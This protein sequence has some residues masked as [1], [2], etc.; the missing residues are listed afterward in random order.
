MSAEQLE[1][2]RQL[3][4]TLTKM[5][6]T[7]NAIADAVVWVG[8]DRRIQWCNSRFAG[9][10][11]RP[12]SEISGCILSDLL[13]LAQAGK[14]VDVSIYPDV[15]INSGE[16]E[17]TDYEFTQGEVSLLLQISGSCV[18]LNDQHCAVLIIR[19]VTQAQSDISALQLREKALQRSEAQYRD[20]VQTANCII[21]RWDYNGNIIFLNDYGQRFFGFDLDEILGRNVIGT[22]VPE[23]ETSGR[24]LEALMVD[25]CLHPENYL[26]NENENICKNGDRVWIVWANKPILDD[27]GNLKEILSVGTDATERQRAEAALQQSELQ[28]RSIVENANDLIFT[29]TADGIFTYHSP[30]VTRILGYSVAELIGHSIVEFTDP[31]SLPTSYSAMES[32]ISGEKLSGVEVRIKHKNGSYR[33][34][35]FNSSTVI[36]PNGEV[37]IA[38]VGRDITERK[39]TEE[40]LRRSEM[41]YRHIFENS[42]VGILRVRIGDGLILDANQ[43]CADIMG[44]NSPDELINQH[45]TTEFYVD[46][47]ERNRMFAEVSK[48]G[49]VNAFPVSLRHVNGSIIY[50]LLSIRVNAAESCLDCVFTDITDRKQ[51]EQ[52]LRL[53]VEGTAAKTGDEFFNSCVGYLAQALQ[54]HYALITEFADESKTRVRT[55]AFWCGGEIGD[56]WE[57][58]VHGTPSERTLQGNLCSYLQGVQAAFPQDMDLVK[59]QAESFVGVPITSS[60]G[61]ILGHLAVINT[62]PMQDDP[63][64]E[65]IMRIFAARAGAELERKQAELALAENQA[66]FRLM[67]ENAND[68][69][70]IINSEGVFA[71]VSPNVIYLTGWMACELEGKLFT[72]FIHPDD[73]A[74]CLQAFNL[75]ITTGEKESILEFRLLHKDGSWLWQQSNFSH[76]E[77]ANGDVLIVAVS[78][79][80]NERK[81]AEA[82]IQRRAQAE[83]LLSRISRQFIDKDVDTAVN[84]TLQAIA[85]FLNGEHSCIQLWSEDL[86]GFYLVYEWCAS[87]APPLTGE[88]RG[89]SAEKFPYAYG[90]LLSGNCLHIPCVADLPDDLPEKALFESQSTKSI[91]V[92]PMIHSEKMVGFL[93][94]DVVSYSK[95]WSQEDINL[96]KLVAEIIAIGRARHEAEE[97]LRVAKDVAEAANRAKSSFLAN[98]SH[99]LRTPLNAIL[100]FAQLISRDPSITNKHRESLATINRSGEHLLNLIN[101][102][103]E[104]SK[105]EA[106]H[107]LFNPEDFDLHLLLQ[108]L[109][110][111]FHIRAQAK[112]LLLEFDIAPDLP[113]YICTDEGK[114]RQVLINLL[115]NAV[116]FTASGG[117]TLRAKKGI[118]DESSVC[119]IFAVEDT[120][121][122]IAAVERDNLFQPFYQTTSGLETK[123][124]T[125]LG[126]TISR[127]F[128]QLMGGSI[129][130]TSTVGEGSIFTFDVRVKLVAP[131]QIIPKLT[132]GRVLRVAPGQPKYRIL[133]VDD[134]PENCD[135][136]VQ[137]LSSVGFEM[138][139]AGDGQEAIAIWENWHP[140]CIWMDMRMPVMNGYEATRQIRLRE[141]ERKSLERTMII[142][143]TAS[144]FEE[145]RATILATGCD[146]MVRKPFREQTI[147]DKLAEHL[148]VQYIYENQPEAVAQPLSVTLQPS[149]FQV[150]GADWIAALTQAAIEVDGERILQLSQEIS[151]RS[152]AAGLIE[153]VNKFA[154]DEILGLLE[155]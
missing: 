97:A 14:P 51:Q 151:D 107:I 108:T 133:V 141:Q 48:H 33:W 120:G 121:R 21:L 49:E 76:S 66:K 144:A 47:E 137:L 89:T 37:I 96:L 29:L 1:Q 139:A 78:R 50:G 116:K 122:G 34:I 12:D 129:D 30:N 73:L 74:K 23:T 16:Y 134:R 109:Q 9:W 112:Q 93:C 128:V 135:L 111:M 142:A 98:M 104:M 15:L 100:G 117:V 20:L 119:L 25:I 86:S 60:G 52:A 64:R 131:V 132:R 85:E 81:Q 71:Y 28:F 22:I 26:F 5:E 41:K 65:L 118:E 59:M 68:C 53:I 69:I 4:A 138:Q 13:P 62:K 152:L 72:P 32:T 75:L 146:D 55:L 91:V 126:L 18:P 19:D 149:C 136:I 39:E 27:H 153:L 67:V 130:F 105:I 84:Y 145:Q 80:I 148:G 3:Q 92:V 147:F 43:R 115:G 7:L 127:Q 40:A 95:T 11:H 79:N 2:V 114:L 63:G 54:V 36:S 123:E 38:G 35:S 143:L 90:Q 103:L 154:F 125:G 24:D 106:G 124:G 42:I 61:E 150:M 155:E 17:T 99:E 101:D 46:L 88:A 6:V 70:S 10:L 45:Y 113:R 8:E 58:C 56:K 94:V 31:D 83:S 77:Y 44:F 140:D 110:E 57:Y 87:T 82:I 102:V